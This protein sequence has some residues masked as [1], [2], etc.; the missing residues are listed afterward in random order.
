MNLRILLAAGLVWSVAARGADLRIGIIG[1]DTSHVVAFTET[2]NNP[3]AK[4]HVPGGKVVAAFKGGSSDIPSSIDRIAGYSK[5]LREKYGVKFYDRIE[6]MCK[7][8]DAVLLESVDGRPHL[9]QARPVLKARKPVFIDKPMAGSLQDVIE[10]FRLARE[11]KVPVFSSSSLRFA[12]NTQA[13]RNGLIGRVRY[14]ETYSPCE[15]EPHHPDLFWYGVHGVES[16]FTIMGTG[17]QTVQRQTTLDGKIEVAGTWSGGRKGVFREGQD[18][19]GLAKGEKGE[20][21]V[22]AFDGYEPLVAVIMKFFQTGVAPVKPEETVEIMAFM[23][24]ADV[25][26]AEGGAVVKI[27][28]ASGPK[29][30]KIGTNR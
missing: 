6:E 22:G 10:I 17:C 27:V 5:T 14:A 18:Y 19:H 23:E 9:E 25:S 11:A 30:A 13:V 16:L 2:L 3:E 26:K 24:A 20:A 15:R 7:D 4:G 8:V 12:R 28:V 21:A 1:C 29:P